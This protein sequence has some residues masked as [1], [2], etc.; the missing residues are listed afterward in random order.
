MNDIAIFAVG[1]AVFTVTLLAVLWA[2]YLTFARAADAEQPGPDPSSRT[3]DP[4]PLLPTTR[5]RLGS[6]APT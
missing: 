3:G 2:G 6:L 5:A 1:V 4:G